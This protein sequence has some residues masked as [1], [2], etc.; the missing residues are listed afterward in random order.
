MGEREKII[1]HP[2]FLCAGRLAARTGIMSGK[3][4]HFIKKELVSLDIKKGYLAE[5]ILRTDVLYLRKLVEIKPQSADSYYSLGTA[6]IDKKRFN[7]AALYFKKAALWNANHIQAYLGMARAYLNLRQYDEAIKALEK[8]A[9]HGGK[10]E[11]FYELGLVYD[12]KGMAEKA[13][14]SLEKALELNPELKKARD[15]LDSLNE[16]KAHESKK[17][18]K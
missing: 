5:K 1:L 15:A 6:L 7:E 8:A 17:R 14:D 3:A 9:A 16:D 10:D 12:K 11:V 2:V 18:K 13:V 4:A